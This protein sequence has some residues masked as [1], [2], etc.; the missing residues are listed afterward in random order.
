MDIDQKDLD[1]L[2][3]NLNLMSDTLDWKVG[4]DPLADHLHPKVQACLRILDSYLDPDSEKTSSE[5]MEENLTQGVLFDE[6]E[7]D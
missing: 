7:D 2:R 5:L 4:T 3:N 6:R 1:R